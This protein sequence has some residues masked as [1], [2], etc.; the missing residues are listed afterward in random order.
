M[1]LCRDEALRRRRANQ[2]RRR[3]LEAGPSVSDFTAI[4][5]DSVL[6]SAVTDAGR[7]NLWSGRNIQS[8]QIHPEG[9]G[10]YV[11]CVGTYDGTHYVAC[12]DFLPDSQ[13]IDP[14]DRA[15]QLATYAYSSLIDPDGL[16]HYW[17]ANITSYSSSALNSTAWDYTTQVSDAN[18]GFMNDARYPG[19]FHW[20]ADGESVICWRTYSGTYFS[21]FNI[22]APYAIDCATDIQGAGKVDISY[23]NVATGHDKPA[24][25][26]YSGGTFN[27]DGTQFIVSRSDAGFTGKFDVYL[28]DAPYD[29]QNFTYHSTVDLTTHLSQAANGLDCKAGK[30]VVFCTTG[31]QYAVVDAAA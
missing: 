12:T 10:F 4:D 6:M 31:G 24:A 15:G 7:L 22:S 1:A 16:R 25:A 29:I 18:N 14:A 5:N 26:T 27:E 30:L 11:G 21:E 2:K 3:I 23:Q 13:T 28:M 17:C 8:V 9:T 20:G 19:S